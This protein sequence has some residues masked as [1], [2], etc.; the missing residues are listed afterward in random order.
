[1][2]F[3][4]LVVEVAGVMPRRQ[5]MAAKQFSPIFLILPQTLAVV[6]SS[7]WSDSNSGERDIFGRE[8]GRKLDRNGSVGVCIG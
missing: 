3:E 2:R 4:G 6:V 7:N 1:M 8:G 5:P